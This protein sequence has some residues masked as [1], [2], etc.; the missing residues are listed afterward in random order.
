VSLLSS[1][2]DRDCHSLGRL[3]PLQDSNQLSP[4]T[5]QRSRTWKRSIPSR[6][7]R[8]IQS[9]FTKVVRRCRLPDWRNWH[10]IRFSPSSLHR[11]TCMPVRTNR[12]SRAT[13]G[14]VVR[15]RTHIGTAVRAP[16]LSLT[17]SSIPS[18][19]LRKFL[20]SSGPPQ[21]LSRE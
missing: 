9:S 6:S 2:S 5:P 17:S 4:T 13:F 11:Q 8:P 14:R 10:L 21:F 1:S 18:R 20:W 3:M 7:L 16:K 19:I 12:S 15:R